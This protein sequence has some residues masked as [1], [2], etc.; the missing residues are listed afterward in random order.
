MD[1]GKKIN[2]NNRLDVKGL[3]GVSLLVCFYEICWEDFLMV[4]W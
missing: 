2:K 1:E 3:G 4:W